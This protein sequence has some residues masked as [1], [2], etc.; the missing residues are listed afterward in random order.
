MSNDE[1]I[2]TYINLIV[3][4]NIHPLRI[5]TSH[6]LYLLQ[7]QKWN[8]A[9]KCLRETNHAKGTWETS[10]IIFILGFIGLNEAGHWINI[11]IDTTL[12]NKGIILVVDSCGIHNFDYIKSYFRN[13]PFDHTLRSNTWKF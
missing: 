6:F 8:H 7:D 3:H 13:T 11:I 12:D 2:N 9:K 5:V 10:E 4:A 1:V